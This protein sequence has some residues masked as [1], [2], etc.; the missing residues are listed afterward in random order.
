MIS[1]IN[2][3]SKGKTYYELFAYIAFIK[4]SRYWQT[5]LAQWIQEQHM[6]LAT[7]GRFMRFTLGFSTT[8]NLSL[9]SKKTEKPFCLTHSG[10][11]FCHVQASSRL[12]QWR[13]WFSWSWSFEVL[14]GKGRIW[15]C[16]DC[17]IN[18]LFQKTIKILIHQSIN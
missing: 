3:I 11:L 8:F 2:G 9:C 1:F 10:S 15:H 17:S 16:S 13:L 4:A 7:P 14:Q 12:C 18:N 5:G 6:Q